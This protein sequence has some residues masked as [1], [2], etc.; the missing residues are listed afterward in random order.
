MNRKVRSLMIL[1]Q[2]FVKIKISKYSFLDPDPGEPDMATYGPFR[3]LGQVEMPQQ[4]IPEKFEICSKE[5][6]RSSIV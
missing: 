5:I 1:G 2:I 4:K 3:Q 6:G